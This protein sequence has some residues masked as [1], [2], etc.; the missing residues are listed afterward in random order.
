MEE[1]ASCVLAFKACKQQNLSRIIVEGD[2]WNLINKLQNKMS[3][4]NILGMLVFQFL[5]LSCV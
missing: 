3:W 4:K 5:R 2:Y 1:A